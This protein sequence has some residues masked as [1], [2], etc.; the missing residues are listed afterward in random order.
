MYQ[1]YVEICIYILRTLTVLFLDFGQCGISNIRR[2]PSLNDSPIFIEVSG[3]GIS[4]VEGTFNVSLV[5]RKCVYLHVNHV[6][7]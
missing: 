7:V 4:M 5:S 3:W 2:A 6:T 1:L